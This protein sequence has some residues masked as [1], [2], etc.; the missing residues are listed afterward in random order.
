MALFSTSREVHSGGLIRPKN[1]RL[2]GISVFKPSHFLLLSSSQE[3]RSG[4]LIR[5]K[6]LPLGGFLFSNR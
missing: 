6:N 1:L 4:G 3:A 2:G 5:P